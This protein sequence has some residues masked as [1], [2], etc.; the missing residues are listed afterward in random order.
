MKL[1]ETGIPGVWVRHYPTG[2]KRYGFTVGWDGKAI[3]RTSK[4]N[5]ARGAAS[6]RQKAIERVVSGLPLDVEPHGP[7]YT[8]ADA[9]KD[10][11]AASEGL[12]SYNTAG[13]FHAKK[14]TELLGELPVEDLSQVAI[15][16]FRKR[17]NEE[18]VSAATVNR[19]LSFLRA[20]LNHAKG[21][22]RIRGDHYFLRLSKADRRKVFLEET[23]SA[24]LR[25]VS[26]EQLES[27]FSGL[28]EPFQAPARLL[29]ATAC[30]K[31]E[32]LGLRWGNVRGDALYI[33]RTKSGKPRT[34][35]LSPEAAKLL[36]QR[37]RDATDENLVFR[38]RDGGGVGNN[39]NRAWDRARKKAELPWLRVHDLRHEGASRFLEAGGTLRE[40][41]VLGGWSSLELVERYSKV[42]EQRIREAL[43]RVPLPSPKSAAEYA[44]STPTEK[45]GLVA[46]AK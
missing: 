23:P 39:F 20:A 33:R 42:N 30:R 22:G 40:L 5:T 31:G 2:R 14:L 9:V 11:L 18:K 25:R 24:G 12:R 43:S 38:G 7:P 28:P 35:P 13:K 37:P 15:A 1:S 21:E 16:G 41:Q 17:R 45:A 6:E 10:Y 19:A 3:R 36:P 4:I 29:L 26:D 44:V 32:I 46:L 34:V 8:V 27:V